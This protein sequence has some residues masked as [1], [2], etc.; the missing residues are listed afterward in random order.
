MTYNH[1]G[2]TIS[3]GIPLLDHYLEYSD[4]GAGRGSRPEIFGQVSIR[5]WWQGYHSGGMDQQRRRCACLT[6]MHSSP[7]AP[8]TNKMLCSN[9][10]GDLECGASS[11]V[12]SLHLFQILAIIDPLS[13]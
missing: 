12:V 6:E 9:V 5:V 3:S 4:L 1:P 13:S 7:I 11:G 8:N 10:S 2:S